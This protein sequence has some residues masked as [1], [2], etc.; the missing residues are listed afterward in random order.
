[1]DDLFVAASLSEYELFSMARGVYANNKA[2]AV[3]TNDDAREEEV[4]TEEVGCVLKGD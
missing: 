3:Q 4:Q 2:A 1:M